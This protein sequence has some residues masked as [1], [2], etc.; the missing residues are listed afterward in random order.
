MKEEEIENGDCGP[1]TRKVFFFFFLRFCRTWTK[2]CLITSQMRVK[3]VTRIHRRRMVWWCNRLT[4]FTLVCEVT[5][6]RLVLV[7]QNL[8][9]MES[10]T[11]FLVHYSSV[12]DATKFLL[13]MFSSH[14]EWNF[15]SWWYNILQPSRAF[16]T[17][18]PTGTTNS[19]VKERLSIC[20]EKIVFLRSLVIV[21]SNYCLQVFR[22]ESLITNVCRLL[23]DSVVWLTIFKDP[24]IPGWSVF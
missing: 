10:Y 5:R 23:G 4:R 3:R 16:R 11:T 21:C 15:C 1:P 12:C 13:S 22:S 17:R 8:K 24:Y 2:R 7:R 6:Y 18:T 20:T 19:F 9:E 14:S